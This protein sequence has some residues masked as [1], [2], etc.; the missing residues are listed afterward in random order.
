MKNM[1]MILATKF[2]FPRE[3]KRRMMTTV[4]MV[5]LTGSLVSPFPRPRNWLALGMGRTRSPASAWRVR[6]ATRIDP[7]ADEIVAAASPRGMMGPHRA[8]SDMMNW[9]V[10]SD[11]A[12]AH[13]ASLIT[14]SI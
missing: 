3:T 14:T 5:A 2:T 13:L 4:T 9:F 11:S 12:E 6:G 8:M 10:A 7:M 1:L